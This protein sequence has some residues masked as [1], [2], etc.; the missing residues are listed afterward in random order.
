MNGKGVNVEAFPT[1]VDSS[2]RTPDHL[3][4]RP[5]WKIGGKDYS[6]VSVDVP[7]YGT[8][9]DSSSQES[10]IVEKR[11]SVFQAPDA[12]ELYTPPESYEGA[13]RFDPTTK[14]TEVEEAALVRRLDWK[15]ALPACV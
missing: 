3:K 4:S 1:A 11:N 14:W 7:N 13:H 15:I 8:F 6:H 5:W 9:D 10:H 12:V 2:N